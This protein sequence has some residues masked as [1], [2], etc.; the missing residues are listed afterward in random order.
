MR[1]N[2]LL[3]LFS[4][5]LG[6]FWAC[7]DDEDG[8]YIEVSPVVVD[9]SQVPYEKLSDYKFFVGDMKELKPALGVLPYEPVSSLFS[10]YAHKKRFVWMPSGTKATFNGDGN[11]L[12]FPVGAVLIKNFYYEDVQNVT[13]VGAARII[14]TR[15]MIRKQ[16][17][18]LF[19]DYVWNAEQTEAYY[20]IAGS[21][22]EISWKDGNNQVKSTSYRIPT[23]AQ[24]IVCHKKRVQTNGGEETVYVP[25]GPKPQNLNFNYQYESG[26]QNQL[27]KWMAVGYLENGP[28]PLASSSAI[29]YSDAS[30]PLELRVRSYADAN[31]A[32]CHSD[33][34]HCDYRPMRFAFADTGG[35]NGRTNLGV[36]VDTQDMQGFPSELNKIVNPGRPMQSML[37][38]RIN[39]TNEAYRMPLHGR[40]VIHEEGVQLFTEWINSLQECQ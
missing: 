25:I 16:D 9:L 10:D 12:E 22:T 18:W 36:C 21:Y 8:E 11:A 35:E 37:H 34:R 31:C 6:L 39:T 7:S 20:D 40:T 1:H 23:L 15:L 26:S 32:H 30:Q 38:Y 3:L 2:Y 19:A 13:P 29:D 24:C 28:L 27:Q 5:C 33:M 17:G 4:I 14:E